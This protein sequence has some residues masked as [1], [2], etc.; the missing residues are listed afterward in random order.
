MPD[1]VLPHFVRGY[2]DGDGSVW[3]GIIHKDRETQHL[4]IQT[5]F[6]SGCRSF[7]EHLSAKLEDSGIFG[8]VSCE[9]GYFRLTYSVLS[10][11]KLAEFMYSNSTN[12]PFLQRKKRVFDKFLKQRMRL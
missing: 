4:A 8:R 2:F 12:K 7:L 9:K 10:S 3:V 6:T 1:K 11:L 5:V